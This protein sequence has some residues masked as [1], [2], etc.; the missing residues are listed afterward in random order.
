MI[1][2]SL[3]LKFIYIMLVVNT[4]FGQYGKITGF[5]IDNET[6]L[7]L[8]GVNVIVDKTYYGA[9]TDQDGRYFI[10]NI[11]PRQYDVKA[12]MIG[13]QAII[14]KNV[15]VSNNR[16]TKIDFLLD[17]SPVELE[18]I[19]VS[20]ERPP[21]IEDQTHSSTFVHSEVIENSASQGLREIIDLVSSISKESDGSFSVR[22]GPAD[23][24]KFY[25]NGVDQSKVGTSRPGSVGQ[26]DNRNWLQDFNPLAVREMEIIVGGF[27]AEYGQAQSG[28]VNVITKDGGSDI[29]GKLQYEYGAPGK[30]HYGHYLYDQEK[31]VEW[32]NWGD[33]E[34]WIG[35]NNTLSENERLPEDSLSFLYNKWVE[36]HTPGPDHLGGAYD[37]RKFSYNRVLFGI[38]GPF[39]KDLNF[40]IS[41][42]DRKE[43]TRIPTN[44]QINHYQNYTLSLNKHFSNSKLYFTGQY[45]HLNGGNVGTYQSSITSAGRQGKHK[46]ALE[47]D[48]DRNEYV[49]SQSLKWTHNINKSAFYD[50]QLYHSYEMSRCV[51]DAIAGASNPWWIVGGP[52]D[53]GYLKNSISY[54]I[55]T[56]DT[57]IHIVRA[58]S[59]VTVQIGNHHLLKAG[60]SAK[61]M[62]IFTN[63]ESTTPNRWITSFSYS[64][65][66]SVNPYCFSAYIQDKMEFGQ[67]IA[68]VGARVDGYNFNTSYYSNRFNPF[69]QGTGAA[70]V[71]D[72]TT[73]YSDLHVIVSPRLGI[74]YPI[75]EYT[76]FHFQYGHFSAMPLF[77]YGI[78]RTTLFGWWALGNPDIDYNKTVSYEFGIQHNMGGQHR[79]DAT[80]FYNDRVDQTTTLLIHSKTGNIRKNQAY[81]TYD[82]SGYGESKGIEVSFENIRNSAD[83]RW[84]Y[85]VS[86][87]LSRTSGGAYG[88]NEL[89]SDDP[90]DPRNY[91]SKRSA[92]ANLSGTDRLH[93][94]R[95]FFIYKTPGKFGPKM[96]TIHPFGEVQ[97]RLIY[98]MQS[99]R[100]F[101][102]VTTFDDYLDMSNNR[103][104]PL[105]H[106]TNL[107]IDRYISLKKLKSLH[108]GVRIE[109]LFNNK[110]LT[111]MNDEDIEKWV[112][113]NITYDD[114]KSPS[115]TYNY[116]RT[117]WNEPL[118]VYFTLGIDF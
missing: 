112:T 103:R 75:S 113:K 45:A 28:V 34:N 77:R 11:R 66:Y 29:S 32:Q 61:Y 56:E 98:S 71:G 117:Y 104:Y 91:L 57:R 60:I 65:Y 18:A 99:G 7:P 70:A 52:W 14:K 110:W 5:I 67:M 95:A 48:N 35:W 17:T 3:V 62:D 1:L 13:Y 19:V 9:V 59:S 63:N 89:W 31:C 96:L 41:G 2:R 73:A 82:N 92:N 16:T 6:H 87:T 108:F 50:I 100:P 84:Y 30:Y 4:A 115:F 111:P 118:H 53:E 21:I 88:S 106:K 47:R 43:P 25:V 36:N 68:N 85:K 12:S 114:P 10:L 33:I 40:F 46:Y 93:K 97:I 37:Y 72:P 101:T 83:W 109:N 74:S 81:Q 15:I 8:V 38:G 80:L 86:Y 107:R 39:G 55:F 58:I 42:E 94:M 54:N 64:S 69:Y 27:N 116:F 49:T 26:L 78:K 79:F 20:A 44:Q 102:Y 90:D 51:Q 76:A 22:G 24:L 105:E 23:D